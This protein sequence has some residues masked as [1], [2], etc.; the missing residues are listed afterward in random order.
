MKT[1]SNLGLKKPEGADI[2]DIND[3]NGNMDILDT[4]VKAVQDHTSDTT[5]HIT[6]AERTA[7]NAKANKSDIPS[8]LPASGGNADTVD[9]F[10][11]S[12]GSAANSIVAQDANQD[13]TVRR[14][15]SNAAQGTAP[16]GVTSTTAVTNLNADMVD[17]YNMNQDVQTTASP[18]FQTVSS[19]ASNGFIAKLAGYKSWIMYR[20]ADQTLVLTPST[21]ANGTAPSLAV[22][23][24]YIF[25]DSGVFKS[26]QLQAASGN[27][28]APLVISSTTLVANLNADMIDGFHASAN[29]G[30]G[31][32][33]AVRDASGFLNATR[34]VSVA[35][36]G[37]A[38]LAVTSTT[39]VDNLNA[40][41][42][43]GLHADSFVKKQAFSGSD[44]NEMTTSGLFRLGANMSNSPS[45]QGKSA[46]DYGQMFVMAA[47]G[48]TIM[49]LAA[50]YSTSRLVFRV[51]NPPQLGGQGAYQEWNEIY[52]SKNV[53]KSMSAPS[54]GS[55]GDIWLQYS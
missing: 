45:A 53:T 7:W 13:I 9:G 34:F 50:H 55:E 33:A 41:L 22:N 11:A 47:G 6:A 31:N 8:S 2:V 51:G 19:T 14:F 46:M 48:D 39:L 4:A 30:S 24:S 23:T 40:D 35:S 37:S 49:Q 42:L 5:R 25:S 10:H 15:I 29:G 21:A 26:Y 54:G 18:S 1:T 43:D 44:F 17:G 3:L 38:P 28:T 36:T 16:F 27:G 52:T 20:P 32:T 12:T